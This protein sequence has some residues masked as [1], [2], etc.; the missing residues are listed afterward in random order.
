MG[1]GFQSFTADGNEQFNSQEPQMA[2]V[3]KQTFVSMPTG[4]FS[5]TVTSPVAPIIAFDADN[6]VFMSG[7][8][9][10][11]GTSWTVNFVVRFANTTVTVYA[12]DFASGVIT[13]SNYGFQHFN[14][15]GVILHD[16]IAGKYLKPVAQYDCNYPYNYPNIHV[17]PSGKVHAVAYTA[18]IYSAAFVA[19][20]NYDRPSVRRVGTT[21]SV[22]NYS[23]PTGGGFGA[24]YSLL[25]KL[26]MVDVTNY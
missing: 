9:N 14:S 26:L 15:S 22:Q 1:D 6:Y 18:N 12:F 16:A 13:P 24:S 11:S 5:F 8:T 10:T 25:G 3:K 4:T 23:T 17:M 7:A 2:L 20:G 19:G 21:I